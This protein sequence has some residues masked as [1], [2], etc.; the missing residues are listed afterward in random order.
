M[1]V[2]QITNASDVVASKV[3]K[4][5][6]FLTPDSMDHRAVEDQIIQKLIENLAAE[7]IEGRI[8]SI[9]GFELKGDSITVNSELKVRKHLDF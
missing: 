1:I 5:F 9:H 2:L 7:G 6:E 3:G 8:A 4:F